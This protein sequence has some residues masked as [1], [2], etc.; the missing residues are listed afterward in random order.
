MSFGG[1][2]IHEPLP[3]LPLQAAMDILISGSF[4]IFATSN[5]CGQLF[6]LAVSGV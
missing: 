1:G 5:N 4:F 6:R 2:W 3:E